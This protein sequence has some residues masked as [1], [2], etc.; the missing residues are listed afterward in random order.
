[1]VWKWNDLG[2]WQV[3][4]PG[5]SETRF[6]RQ[7]CAF[8]TTPLETRRLGWRSIRLWVFISWFCVK[9]GIHVKVPLD[10]W[11]SCLCPI[12]NRHS[13]QSSIRLGILCKF[14]KQH[15]SSVTNWCQGATR[16]SIH[17]SLL[18][19]LCQVDFDLAAIKCTWMSSTVGVIRSVLQ[20][21]TC[22]CCVHGKSTCS[23]HLEIPPQVLPWACRCSL[24]QLSGCCPDC[25]REVAPVSHN[26]PQKN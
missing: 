19:W 5:T 22:H 15:Q 3:D 4:V 11:Y 17:V 25:L 24:K 6:W 8:V 14:H 12:R 18:V 2:R 16:N 13:C 23:E 10:V 1:M 9:L 20:S 26:S 7:R 21:G